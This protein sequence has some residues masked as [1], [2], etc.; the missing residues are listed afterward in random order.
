MRIVFISGFLNSHVKPLCDEFNRISEFYFIAT[1]NI[2]VNVMGGAFG[3]NTLQ[4]SYVIKSFEK[5]NTE[6]TLDLIKSAEVVIFGGSSEKFIELRMKENRLS[7]IYSERFFKKGRWRILIPS[8]FSAIYNKILRYS[9]KNMYALCAGSFTAKDLRF[10]G[11]PKGKCF[12]FGYFPGYTKFETNELLKFKGNNEIR[13]LFAGRLISL[14][15][16]HDI[17]KCAKMLLKAGYHFRLDIA[18]D[19]MERSNLENL[20]TNLKLED[21]VYFHGALS[22]EE[23]YSF[24]RQSNIL[25]CSSNFMEGWGAVVNEALGN[26]CAVIVSNAVGSASYLVKDG[27]NGY[28]YSV[29]NIKDMYRKTVS[30]ISDSERMWLMS[31][32][33]YETV[34]KLWN[35][36][37]AAERFMQVADC[38]L[39][40]RNAD[41]FD[42]GPLSRG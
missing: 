37:I 32:H 31:L 14:K 6:R 33:A 36:R 35:A 15:R 10:C 26:G 41:L 24:M 4:A 27:Y 8:T 17:I 7:F 11:Y 25:Y 18:G 28:L 19:G 9:K 38:L 13:L 42:E 12:K 1:Q 2:K 40:G 20:V 5:Q 29:A 3:K 22:Q 23:T 39:Q 21:H 30:V 34:D 16:T